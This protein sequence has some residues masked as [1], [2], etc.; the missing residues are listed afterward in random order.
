MKQ[1]N[2]VRAINEALRE[3]MA[4]D[5][6]VIILGEDVGLSGGSFSATRGLF[7]EFGGKRVMDTPISESAIAG[8]AVGA[9]MGGFRPVAEIMFMDFMTLAMDSV[10]NTAAKMRSIFGGQYSVPVVYLTQGGGGLSAGPH[11]SQS[12]EA[13][14]CH[15]PGLKVV[16]PSTPYDVKGLLK[17]AIRDD[18]PVVFIEHKSLRVTGEIP[19]EEY[20]IPLGKADIK[21]PGSDVTV[22]TWGQMYFKVAAAA[23][24]LKQEGLEIEILDLRTLIPLDMEAITQSVKKTSRLVIAHEAV[25]TGGFGAE[26]AAGVMDVLFDSLDAPIKR[27]GAAFAPIP[28]GPDL[29]KAVLPQEKDVIAAVKQIM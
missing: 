7:S 15:V 17:S 28:W 4:R 16:Y 3:E 19:E 10:A 9:A 24:T 11:H 13:W 21:R 26:I 1:I 12:L 22:V 27:V 14:F 18:N 25:K 6:R 29:E 8:V 23:E 2:Y 20:T 5:E